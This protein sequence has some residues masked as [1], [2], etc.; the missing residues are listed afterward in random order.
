MKLS[1]K[2]LD[3]ST[4]QMTNILNA[5]DVNALFVGAS[6]FYNTSKGPAGG[7]WGSEIYVMAVPILSVEYFNLDLTPES[8]VMHVDARIRHIKMELELTNHFG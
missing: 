3:F 8:G 6:L 4:S 7:T 5:I 2:G 1:Q